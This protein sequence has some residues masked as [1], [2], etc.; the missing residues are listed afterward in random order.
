MLAD[1]EDRRREL[2]RT[3]VA[4]EQ[5]EADAMRLSREVE[6]R[7][8]SIEQREAAMRTAEREALRAARAMA[9]RYL[10]D[11]RR[12][13][14]D[15][16]ILARAAASDTAA[17]A[18]RRAIEDALR[19]T[20]PDEAVEPPRAGPQSVTAQAAEG[21]RVRTPVGAVGTVREVRPDGRAVVET[22]G[23]RLVLDHAGLERIGEAPVEPVAPRGDAP[24][25]D[26]PAAST[27]DLRGL[28]ADEAEAVLLRAIDDGVRAALPELTVIHGKGTGA[29]RECVHRLVTTDPR[30]AGH[31]LASPAAGGAGVTLIRFA[32]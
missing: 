13:V 7:A 6:E 8:G 26:T 29:L 16:L 5:R 32:P 12:Q 20:L 14:E 18:A 23:V 17:R 27:V 9:R 28:R 10:L 3:G 15:A 11:A 25:A 24:E 2:E 4:L 1:L 22:G 31:R 19:S 30:V 21:D